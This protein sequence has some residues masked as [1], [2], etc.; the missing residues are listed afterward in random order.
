MMGLLRACYTR[1]P[2]RRAQLSG[3]RAQRG[4]K[5]TRTEFRQVN[6]TW[7]RTR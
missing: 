2:N 4:E 3:K 1:H 5:L 6:L 7:D